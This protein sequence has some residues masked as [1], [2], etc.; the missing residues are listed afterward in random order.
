MECSSNL[1]VF[2]NS[3]TAEWLQQCSKENP[4]EGDCFR[5]M[6]EG[7]FPMLAKGKVYIFNWNKMT[8]VFNSVEINLC[9]LNSQAFRSW[10][11][12]I[13]NR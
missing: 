8:E 2:I 10:E 11:S 1:F 6:F 9:L 5:Q 13:L 4:N 12:S 7:M 3:F